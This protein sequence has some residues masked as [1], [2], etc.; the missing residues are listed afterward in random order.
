MARVILLA[1]AV[2]WTLAGVAALAVAALGTAAL[3]RLLPPLAID[4]DALRAAVT[5]LGAGLL[6]VGLTHVVVLIGLRSRSRWGWS[7]ATLLSAVLAATMVA[8][9]AASAASAVATPSEAA[10]LL[11]AG[12]A[13]A[14]AAGAYAVA[15][16]R[17]VGERRSGSAH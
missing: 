12:A 4:T 5:A 7:G 15:V 13:A 10:L 8:L 16:I 11:A 6:A 17:L 2:T 3:E 9:C 1:G 14:L